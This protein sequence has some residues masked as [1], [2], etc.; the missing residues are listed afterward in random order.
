[1]RRINHQKAITITAFLLAVVVICLSLTA[2][3]RAKSTEKFISSELTEKA[4]LKGS[5]EFYLKPAGDERLW[6]V[7]NT[8][9]SNTGEDQCNNSSYLFSG[10]TV[11]VVNKYYVDADNQEQ[12]FAL[13]G[14]N[15]TGNT[16]YGGN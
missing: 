4:S 1:M 15:H 13:A 16:N 7:I 6:H 9:T 11:L 12:N 5:S 3:K 2:S 8:Y 10:D 14:I